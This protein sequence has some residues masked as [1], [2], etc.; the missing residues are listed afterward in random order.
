MNRQLH[1]LMMAQYATP[2]VSGDGLVSWNGGVKCVIPSVKLYGAA[3]QGT[4]S[5]S[6]M[7]NPALYE[8][9]SGYTKNGVTLTINDDGS[10][11]ASGTPTIASGRIMTLYLG[12]Y[13]DVL[14]NGET[15]IENG[16]WFVVKKSDGTQTWPGTVT[17]DTDTMVSIRPYFEIYLDDYSNGMT[18]Y[19]AIN[20]GTTRLPWERYCGGIPAPNPG[21]PIMPVC[22]DGVV[23]ARG[24]N[25]WND[26][27][28]FFNK[29]YWERHDNAYV[30]TRTNGTYI[31]ANFPLFEGEAYTL[32]AYFDEI[33]NDRTK[34]QIRTS[35]N[36]I[37]AEAPSTSEVGRVSLTFVPKKS[38]IYRFCI[39]G[40]STGKMTISRIQLEVGLSATDYTPYWDGG[41]A[42]SPELWAIPGTDIRDEWDA[43]TGWGVRRCAVIDSYAGE[44]IT[45]PYISST[46]ELS[47]GAM[48][49]YGI[50]DTPFYTAPARLTQPNGPGQ[51]I[52]VSG[53]VPDCPI[54]ANYL[55]HS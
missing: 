18:R 16:C 49:V 6:N 38:E 7:L 29:N 5:G 53:S 19:I 34:V 12:E 23:V 22:N 1:D 3:N 20:K 52:Q 48:V 26:Y 24:K 44:Q 4:M 31:Y 13:I 47:E 41:Q 33:E 8:F 32:S 37:S 27:S 54:E 11:T 55:T 28:A 42:T 9:E 10:I 39:G 35:D 30:S 21:Y 45:T 17:V 46:G 43:Q 2:K 14:K 15:Y 25:L 50:P 40:H 51:I 36:V